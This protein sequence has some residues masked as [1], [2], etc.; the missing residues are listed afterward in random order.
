MLYKYKRFKN[1][2][3]SYTKEDKSTKAAKRSWGQG[4]FADPIF[5]IL[6]GANKL[7]TKTYSRITRGMP[8]WLSN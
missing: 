5:K 6:E 8:K 3:D 1:T 2:K 4:L 7:G